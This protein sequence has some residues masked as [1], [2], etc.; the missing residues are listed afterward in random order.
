MA[1]LAGHSRAWW[2][3]LP[4]LPAKGRTGFVLI[5][6]RNVVARP[7]PAVDWPS[8]LRPLL[9]SLALPA[10]VA[11]CGGDATPVQRPDASAAEAAATPALSVVD[12]AGRR[13]ELTAPAQRIVSLVPSITETIAALGA[14]DR[15]VGRTDYDDAPEFAAIPSVGGGLTPS[16]E[17]IAALRPDLVVAW[18]EAG[19]ARI[20]PRLEEMGIRVF[21]A[22]TR[23][24]ADVYA[25][26]ERLGR[27][28]AV[29]AAADSVAAA[30]RADLDAVRRSVEGL[31]RPTVLY[32]IGLDPPIVAGPQVF[33]GEM[34]DIAGG[35]NVFADVAAPSPQVSVEEIVRRAPDVVVVPTESD[36]ATVLERMR[37]LAGWR[38]L[39]GNGRSRVVTIPV[40]L[41]HRPGPAIGNA[42]MV[43]RDAIHGDAHR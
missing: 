15:I 23:D 4:V 28:L 35:R 18:E 24:T 21:A 38:E 13:V 8:R 2:Q 34:L 31:D 19:T 9:L 6:F 3:P 29:D 40:D 36:Q 16:L 25:N 30:V 33:I 41:L 32:A 42:A 39:L 43:L 7:R 11:A 22:Q 12:D 17:A 37:E 1:A 5:G 10:L 26:I 27:L 20:R 14:A